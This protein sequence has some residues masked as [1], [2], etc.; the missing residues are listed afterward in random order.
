MEDEKLERTCIENSVEKLGYEKPRK[1]VCSQSSM[2][3]PGGFI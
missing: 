1:I 2:W 3:A